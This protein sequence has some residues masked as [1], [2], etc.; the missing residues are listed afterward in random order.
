MQMPEP[1]HKRLG[2]ISMSGCYSWQRENPLMTSLSHSVAMQ[3]KSL[4]LLTI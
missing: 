2:E 3:G 1:M 4:A